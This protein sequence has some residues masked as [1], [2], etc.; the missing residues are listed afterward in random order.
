MLFS[1]SQF[2]HYTECHY[3]GCHYEE[4]HWANFNWTSWGWFKFWQRRSVD[5]NS[6]F[7]TSVFRE[8]STPNFLNIYKKTSYWTAKTSNSSPTVLTIVNSLN[9]RKKIRMKAVRLLFCH[10]GL[11]YSRNLQLQPQTVNR[12]VTFQHLWPVLLTYYDHKW[13]DWCYKL[14]HHIYDH[15]WLH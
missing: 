14:W 4:C 10:C 6:W 13:P 15:K 1:V 7:E 11:S 2:T 5:G 9:S 3:A 8:T 12:N